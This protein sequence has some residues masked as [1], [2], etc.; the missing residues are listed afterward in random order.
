MTSLL[1]LLQPSPPSMK[2]CLL[3]ISIRLKKV[4]AAEVAW[5]YH[6]SAP[7]KLEQNSVILQ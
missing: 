5:F 4:G 2:G 6:H 3:P 7:H 1:G